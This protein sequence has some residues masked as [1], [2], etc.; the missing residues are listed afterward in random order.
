MT[1]H[2]DQAAALL[3]EATR[4]ADSID[5]GDDPGR[6]DSLAR[7]GQIRATAAVSAA[8]LDVAAAIRGSGNPWHGG[9]R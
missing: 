4:I 3:A 1:E 9:S 2:A 6:V 7:S 5:D 8:L